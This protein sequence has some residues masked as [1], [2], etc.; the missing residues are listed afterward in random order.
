MAQAR[1]QSTGGFT[2]VHAWMIGFVFLWLTTTVLLVWLYTEQ[3]DLKNTTVQLQKE[4]NRL[5]RSGDKSLPWYGQSSDTGASMASLLEDARKQTAM[6]A[7]GEEV[8]DVAAARSKVEA[9][10]GQIRQEG[11][12]SDVTVYDQLQMLPGMKFLYEEFRGRHQLHAE[13][14]TRAVGAESRLREAIENHDRIETEFRATSDALKEQIVKLEKERANYYAERDKEVD[15][16]GRNMDDMRQE[17]SRDLQSRANEIEERNQKYGELQSRY[18]ELQTKL[19]ELQIKPGEQ[20][21]LRREDGRITLVDGLA[22]YINLGSN[23]QLT[24]GLQ[25]A[26]YPA[27]G[28]PADGRTKARIEVLR[29]YEDIS[30]CRILA[31][32]PSDVVVKDDL[33]ANPVYDP[34]RPLRFVVVGEFDLDGDGQDD[35]EGVERVASLIGHWGGEVADSLTSRVDFVV[36]GFAPQVPHFITTPGSTRDRDDEERDRIIRQRL[37]RYNEVLASAAA[38]SIPVLTQDVFVQFLGF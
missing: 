23:H 27:T 19:G 4:N 13:A 31:I 16:L 6:L 25:F 11:L 37:E 10:F 34:R 32:D 38:L 1:S 30:E 12:V 21:S 26:V 33:I 36:A 18:A 24:P 15:D 28:I 29:I 17:H 3:E 35:S 20:L 9:F 5:A 14:N 2:A 22:V 7:V 8:P